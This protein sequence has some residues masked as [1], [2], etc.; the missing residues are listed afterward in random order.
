M[1]GGT[2]IPLLDEFAAIAATGAVVTVA[3]AR[4][5]LPAVAGLLLAGALIGPHALGVVHSIDAIEILAE[6]GVVLLL[7]TIGLEF[8][9][10][11]LRGIVGRASIAGTLQVVF[12]AAAAA[13]VALAAGRPWREAVFW[14]FAIALSSTAIVLRALA[15]RREMDAPHG[16]I[17]VGTLILQDLLVVPMVLIVPLLAVDR[18]DGGILAPLGIAL[19]KALAVALLAGVV[20][21]R[22][23]P[24]A[25]GGVA[26]AGSREVFLL[27]VLGFCV[28]MASLT[29]AAGLSLALG[30]FVAGIVLADSGFA[31]RALGETLP[32]RDVFMS[33]FFVSIGMLFDV[34]VVIAQPVLV[35]LIVLA[36]LVGKG[37]IASVAAIVLRFPPR[38]AWLAGVGLAQF[39]EFGF[40]LARLGSQYGVADPATLEVV[41][42]AGT[43]SMFIT[44]LLLA[45]APHVT[46][47]EKVLAP[48]TRLLGAPVLENAAPAVA[49]AHD[50]VVV[51]GYGVGGNIITA[52]LLSSSV[53]AVVLELDL[54]AVRRAQSRGLPVFYADAT[55]P[56]AL[57]HA[58]LD[59]ARALVIVINDPGAVERIVEAARKVAPSVRIIV[60]SHYLRE[61]DR[62]LGAGAN[63]VVAD[64]LEAGV[65]ILARILRHLDVPRNLVDDEIEAV[66]AA[67]QPSSRTPTMPRRR[68]DQTEEL[69]DLRFDSIAITDAAHARDRTLRDLDLRG[70]TGALVVA[71]RRGASL[72]DHIDPDLA[73]AEGDTLYLVGPNVAI[74]AAC[75]LLLRGNPR[76]AGPTT[77]IR[78]TPIA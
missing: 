27:A 41:L 12:T 70:R 8:S 13:S 22:L 16:R 60:R 14:G 40:V 19:A 35:G 56:E 10:E 62:L 48:L 45:A 50:H 74:R 4:L 49:D 68:A 75:S 21:R 76:P 32:L 5:R 72:L 54:D 25:F 20:L 55:S 11:R 30:A 29:A 67:T 64:E 51:V 61:R 6:L 17:L 66:R 34:D 18:G 38:A 44:P 26:S 2:T 28:G 59:R 15:E 46:A 23:V 73:L 9:P 39:G 42:A 7:F 3:L 47:G 43:I 37:A 1:A 58:H 52:A 63:D 69:G 53:P 31:T 24:W 77:A 78:L 33:I 65:E 36:L 71:L 57:E